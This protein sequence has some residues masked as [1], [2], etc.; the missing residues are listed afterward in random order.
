[1][2]LKEK[3]LLF[4]EVSGNGEMSVPYKEDTIQKL[5]RYF[6][7]L[8]LCP[9]SVKVL[10]Q[11]LLY[12]GVTVVCATIKFVEVLPSSCRRFSRCRYSPKTVLTICFP[13]VIFI[14]K[15]GHKLKHS[16]YPDGH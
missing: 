2:Y 1:M 11:R 14:G 16:L 9:C 6:E 8:K 15:Q 10:I 7:T 4:R 3:L 12:R 5:I 13:S